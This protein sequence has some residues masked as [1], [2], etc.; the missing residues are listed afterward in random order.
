MPEKSSQPGGEKEKSPQAEEETKKKS[1]VAEEE[2]WK[3]PGDEE[4]GEDAGWIELPDEADSG[5][6]RVVRASRYE[7]QSPLLRR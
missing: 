4:S 6:A 7:S 2:P 1:V 3:S 5:G